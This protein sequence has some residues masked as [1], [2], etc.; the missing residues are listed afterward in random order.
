MRLLFVA[1]IR[2][3]F[4][5]LARHTH[6][7]R[8]ADFAVDWARAARLGEHEVLLLA[9]GAGRR[10]AAQAVD[11]ARPWRPDAIISTGFCG[12]LDREL[13]VAGLVIATA[14]ASGQGAYPAAPGLQAAPG[15]H[16]G[17]VCSIDHVARTAEEKHRLRHT[18]ACAVEMEA[19][20]VAER[21][22]SLQLPFF[23]VRA[24]TDLADET[25]ANDFNAA[26][27]PDG[28][29][30]T[31]NILRGTLRRPMVRLPELFRL[32]QRSMRATRALG[33]FIAGCRF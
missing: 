29:F 2:M 31:M 3:E 12:A 30:D 17:L 15:G 33:D 16:R 1:S 23:C 32:R 6:A 26:L 21:S 11:A 9:N 19:A 10:R 14:V 8:P 7:A 5:G 22:Q 24:V 25:M 27:R 28:H 13:P 4:A 20:G 18:G